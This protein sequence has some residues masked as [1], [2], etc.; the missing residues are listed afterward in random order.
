MGSGVGAIVG[1]PD[2]KTQTGAFGIRTLVEH[3]TDISGIAHMCAHLPVG[4]LVGET[5]QQDHSR[6]DSAHTLCRPKC[7]NYSV[8]VCSAW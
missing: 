5:A 3:A 6:H 8:C 7:L 2:N 4:D 1:S